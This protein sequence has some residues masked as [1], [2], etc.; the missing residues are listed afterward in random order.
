MFADQFQLRTVVGIVVRAW[1]VKEQTSML[2]VVKLLAPV[3]GQG[4]YDV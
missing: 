1:G 3:A 4:S 2:V